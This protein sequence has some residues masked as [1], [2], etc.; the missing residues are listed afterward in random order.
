MYV[1]DQKHWRRVRDLVKPGGDIGVTPEALAGP[2]LWFEKNIYNRI[3]M[4]GRLHDAIV[5]A[6]IKVDFRVARARVI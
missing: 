4:S 5:A 1:F 2:D 6:R 3:V